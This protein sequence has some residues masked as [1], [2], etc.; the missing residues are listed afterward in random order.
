MNKIQSRDYTVKESGTLKP[1][2]LGKIICE[3]LEQNFA[4]IMDVTFTAQMEDQLEQVAE[5]KK[6]WKEL[7]R[8]FWKDFSP[9]VD[10]AEKD[11]VVPKVLTDRD[12]PKCGAHKLH[13]IWARNNYFYGCSG[14]PEC[15]FTASV[16]GLDFKKEDYEPSF[17]WEQHCPICASTM[18]LR[19][20]RFG[21]FLGCS[22]YPECKGIVNIPKKG[23]TVY[24]QEDLVACPAIGCNGKLTPRKSRF[25]KTFFSCSSFPDCDVIGNTP[26]QTIEK[27]PNHPKTAYVK[28]A[29]GRFGKKAAAEEK[30]TK[31]GKA[32][33]PK[34][35]SNQPAY[36]LSPE[37]AD[38]VGASEMSRPEATKAIW[39]YIK[40]NNLQDAQD[41]RLIVPDAK[42]AKV[43]G[44]NKISMM[45][46]AGAISKHF[47]K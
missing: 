1:T 7:I 16:D 39:V 10:K 9:L 29:K 6:D 36:E 20:G 37:L 23:E 44:K 25:G 3:M 45:K 31:K 43:L 5:H 19:H 38:V 18:T 11:A 30:P 47:K 14:Y 35:K 4:P 22:H 40:A 17:N 27:Y 8:T 2:E 21:A 24:S 42:L 33:K 26:E 41:K 12:C 13:K 34:A 15:D 32:K 28:K 46:I